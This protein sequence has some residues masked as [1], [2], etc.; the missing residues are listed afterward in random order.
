MCVC[1][2]GGVHTIALLWASDLGLQLQGVR[3]CIMGVLGTDLSSS[4]RAK[5]AL[6]D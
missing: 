6:N 4:R 5:N 1:L 3:R 2:C